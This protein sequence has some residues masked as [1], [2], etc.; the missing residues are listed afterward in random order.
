MNILLHGFKW[1]KSGVPKNVTRRFEELAVKQ[2]ICK[3]SEV[4]SYLIKIF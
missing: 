2:N 3:K 1:K 4:A